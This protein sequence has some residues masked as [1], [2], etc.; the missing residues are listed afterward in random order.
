MLCDRSS[1]LS[2][3]ESEGLG[4]QIG[5]DFTGVRVSLGSLSVDLI[6]LEDLLLADFEKTHID[7]VV[8]TKQSET[9]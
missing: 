1:S 6:E 2:L 3:E 9:Q 8:T 4:L 7:G 5:G